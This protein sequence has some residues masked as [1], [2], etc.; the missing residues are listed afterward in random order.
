M[1]AERLA[2]PGLVIVSILNPLHWTKLKE[3]HWWLHVAQ[4][5]SRPLLYQTRP[6]VSYLHFI[7][8]LR[9]SAP[10]FH[11]VGRANAG[12]LV[13]YDEGLPAE[14]AALVGHGRSPS[15]SM[16]AGSVEHTGI[17]AVG[18]LCVSGF[19]ERLLTQFLTPAKRFLLKLAHY[20]RYGPV[21]LDDPQE[22]V[23]VRL[24][25][26]GLPKDVTRNNVIAAL[27]PFTIGVM[28]HR[29]EAQP[30]EGQPFRLTCMIAALRNGCWE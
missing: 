1:F 29:N 28:F 23:E 12:A 8:T 7:Q 19:S 5:R 18:S 21:G 6:Y 9:R 16:G 11:L 14:A 22:E 4:A 13:R 2:P 27:R 15:R 10:Q 26:P 20:A 30:R 3:P 24:H 17:P 25:G